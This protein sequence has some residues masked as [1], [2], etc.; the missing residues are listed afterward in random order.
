MLAKAKETNPTLLADQGTRK[1]THDRRC[2]TP[3]HMNG[4]VPIV[5]DHP[6]Q[7]QPKPDPL[8][9]SLLTRVRC[10]QARRLYVGNLP[11]GVNVTEQMLVDFFN[12]AV[13]AVC[14]KEGG[15]HATWAFH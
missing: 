15:T 13:C 1:V 6:E 3:C 2:D 12:A 14:F 10:S 11:P 9:R 7:S 8:S 4:R 5:D